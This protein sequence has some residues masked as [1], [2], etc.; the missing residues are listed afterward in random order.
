MVRRRLARLGVVIVAMFG[1][2]PVESASAAPVKPAVPWDINGDGYAELALG[3][4]RERG[5]GSP[6]M[7]GGGV[8]TLL[9]GSAQGP[10]GAGSVT[11]SQE[12]PGVA[13]YSE[14]GD[15]FGS[16]MASCDFNR[17]GFA[18]L[19]IGAAGETGPGDPSPG[20][21]AQGAVN[22]LYG[23]ARGV[24][25][26]G[27]DLFSPGEFRFRQEWG[28]ALECGDVNGDGYAELVAGGGGTRGVELGGVSVFYGART[29]LDEGRATHLNRAAVGFPAGEDDFRAS[30]F[31]RSLAVGDLNNDGRDDVVV[32]GDG[33]LYV[34]LGRSGGVTTPARRILFGQTGI[35]QAAGGLG[36]AALAT[37]DFDR[38]GYADI[39]ASVYEVDSPKCESDYEEQFCPD[40]VVV[41]SARSAGLDVAGADLWWADAPGVAGVA[42]KDDNFGYTLAAGDLNR[43]GRDDLAIGSPNKTVGAA[44][45]TGGVTILYGSTAGLTASG[46]QIWTQDSP[47]VP[48]VNET[49]DG[50]GSA[51]LI[52][53]LRGRSGNGLTIAVPSESVGSTRPLAGVATVMFGISSGVT[54]N[55]AKIWSQSSPG[56]A[57]AAEAGDCFGYPRGGV[58][59][60]G[61]DVRC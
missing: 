51:L 44:R 15:E 26:S 14:P 4:P 19:V 47:R 46:S 32:G 59:L 16:A 53:A 30:L 25:T 28:Q 42:D 34:L 13:G 39:A 40:G 2:V 57:G 33:N 37:G 31:G 50:F 54:A 43:D 6:R 52:S 12:S 3:S 7:G 22:V 20:D 35:T 61:S 36:S 29:G 8:V 56:V 45:S 23:S 9:K 21:R 60:R 11:V 58:P 17:D 24:R 55:G 10:V 49:Y 41:I 5:A 27:N 1:L 18:D 38:N 48:G